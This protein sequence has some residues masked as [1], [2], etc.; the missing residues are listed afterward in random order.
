MTA[1]VGRPARRWQRRAGAAVLLVA[2]ALGGSALRARAELSAQ[3]W[4]L[5]DELAAFGAAHDTTSTLELNGARVQLAS[6][7]LSAHVHEVLDRFDAACA[8]AASSSSEA[9]RDAR[10]QPAARA[11]L[12][13]EETADAGMALCLAQ[14]TDAGL[15]SLRERGADYARSGDLSVFGQLRYLRAQRTPHG[16][17][18]VLFAHS[19]GPLPLSAM[20]PAQ[21]DARGSDIA[22][23][24]RPAAARRV[25]SMRLAGRGDAL[26]AYEVDAA[27][28]PALQAYAG[29]LQRNGFVQLEVAPDAA[30]LPRTRIFARDGELYLV[31]GKRQDGQSV[32]AAL[33]IGTGAPLPAAGTALAMPAGQRDL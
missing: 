3:L 9:L 2:V 16:A 22:S 15:R 18:H 24:P 20:F 8:A 1:A 23:L 13:R 7:T 10:G 30:A 26:V 12:L 14:P 29:T 5:G 33:R 6:L 25:L 17:L 28:Q 32:L 31:H 21:G 27:L 19:A 4:Q 11:S